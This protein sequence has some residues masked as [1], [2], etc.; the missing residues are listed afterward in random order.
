MNHFASLQTLNG[1][2]TKTGI[3]I[4]VSVP[5]NLRNEKSGN[6]VTICMV[7]VLFG[8]LKKKSLFVPTFTFVPLLSLLFL[9]K[10]VFIGCIRVLLKLDFFIL[11]YRA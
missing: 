11:E 5:T 1:G 8:F 6:Q 10:S 3:S 7:T 2:E 4:L 9:L